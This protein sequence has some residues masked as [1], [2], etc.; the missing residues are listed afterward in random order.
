MIKNTYSFNIER[1]V[2]DE[3]QRKMGYGEY[4]SWWKWI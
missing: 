2:I 1:K 4:I 3:L